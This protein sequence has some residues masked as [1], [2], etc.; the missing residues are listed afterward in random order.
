MKENDV[1]EWVY[2]RDLG[3]DVGGY[4]PGVEDTD[5]AEQGVATLTPKADVTVPML[6]LRLPLSRLT[7]Q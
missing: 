5:T 7:Q 2:T 6:P 1:V 3:K 4:L